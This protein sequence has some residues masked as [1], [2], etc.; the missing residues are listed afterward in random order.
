MSIFEL[1]TF[2]RAHGE[3]LQY[4]VF[5]GL[6]ATLAALEIAFKQAE[7]CR[8]R[9]WLTNGML[10]VLCILTLGAMPLTAIATAE[11]AAAN[12]IGLLN[13]VPLPEGV[14]LIAGFLIRTLISYLVHVAFHMSPWLWRIHAVHHTDT[15]MDVTTSVRMHP[16]EFVIS[17]AMVLPCIAAF[18][19]PVAAV[20]IYEILDAAMAV[21]THANVRMPKSLDRGLRQVIVTPAMHR[22]HHSAW[23]PETDSNFGATLSLWDRVFGTYRSTATGGAVPSVLG[24]DLGSWRED[25]DDMK[26]LL[27]LPLIGVGAPAAP[28][29]TRFGDQA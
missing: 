2:L 8:G 1:E 12:S 15:R 7:P 18:G 4:A 11:Y 27:L 22:I 26:R 17:A 21:F 25:S 10:T 23:Q 14:V 13:H 24:L 9:R 20:L 3:A 16:L 5:F 6:F 29:G 19:I 28:A